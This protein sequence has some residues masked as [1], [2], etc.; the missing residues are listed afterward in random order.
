MQYA[1]PGALGYWVR[2]KVAY[3]AQSDGIFTQSA[4]IDKV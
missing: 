2:M 4:K 3:F 1:I